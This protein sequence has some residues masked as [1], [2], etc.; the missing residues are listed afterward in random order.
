MARTSEL[1]RN[2]NAR[3]QL[4]MLLAEGNDR[5]AC[6]AVFEVHVDTITR[7]VKDPKVQARLSQLREERINRISRRTDHALEQRLIHHLEDMPTELLLQI[8]KTLTPAP[9][10]AG[11]GD[12]DP[13]AAESDLFQRLSRLAEGDP[14]VAAKLGLQT[15][16]D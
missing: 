7:W 11:S 4:A 3:D 14:H 2:P 8:R 9:T 13:S 10:A 16:E 6:A 1:N 5:P 12:V 15:P